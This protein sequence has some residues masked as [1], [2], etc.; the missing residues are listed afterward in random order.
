MHARL[1]IVGIATAA[2]AAPQA[3]Q[4]HAT[5][6]LAI[7]LTRGG[8]DAGPMLTVVMTNTSREDVCIRAELL[9]NPY[10]YE[11]QIRLINA[12]GKPV[13]LKRSGYLN[14]LIVEPIRI[15]PGSYVEGRYYLNTRFNLP[16]KG[17]SLPADLR[18]RVEFRYDACDGSLSQEATS[19]WQPV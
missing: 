2:C 7:S 16:D 4:R 11:M 14:D 12:H 15:A 9:K 1:L 5:G 17:K 18:A 3:M 6:V 8:D 13:K 10:T 19:I